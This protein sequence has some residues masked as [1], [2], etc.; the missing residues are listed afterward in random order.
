MQPWQILTPQD[1]EQ[2]HQTTLRILGEVGII[3]DDP[4][5]RHILLERARGFS[6]GNGGRH[7]GK[8]RRDC[9]GARPR[10]RDRRD[11]Q[12]YPALAQPGRRTRCLRPRLQ[13]DQAGNRAGRARGNP[14]A[15]CAGTCHHGHAIL[16]TDR[17]A[18]RIDVAG[19][20]PP[21]PAAHHQ[22]AARARR[23]DPRRSEICGC[24]G[25]S[26]RAS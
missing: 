16:Y 7:P 4:D 11:R 14:A 24:H 23:A 5:T 12:R 3:L 1:L 20:V 8:V 21:C 19:D 25:G 18:R 22:T 13:T 17:C 15:G 10:R 2:I 26:D 9:P 6:A